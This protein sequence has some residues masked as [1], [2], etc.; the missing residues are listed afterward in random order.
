ML[1]AL[2]TAFGGAAVGSRATGFVSSR[3]T[4]ICL[5]YEGG[6]QLFF[7]RLSVFTAS[8]VPSDWN[9]CTSSTSK[10][11]AAYMIRYL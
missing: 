4:A 5:F 7:S 1:F 11:T 2:G 8:L 6:G 9:S 10:I 3:Q